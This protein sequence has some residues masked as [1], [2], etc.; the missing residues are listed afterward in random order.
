[1]QFNQKVKQFEIDTIQR[2]NMELFKRM[3]LLKSF[4][5]PKELDEEYKIEH[6]KIVSKIRKLTKG[7]FCFF[8]ISN[9]SN[10]AS[11]RKVSKTEGNDQQSKVEE[12]K[13]KEKKKHKDDKEKVETADN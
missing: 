11:R 9:R 1:M 13:E 10:S 12:S 3:A 2:E 6:Q 8:Y 5:N 7:Q 4:I